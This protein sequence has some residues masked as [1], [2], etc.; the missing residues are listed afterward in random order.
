[1]MLINHRIME[2]AELEGAHQA[3]PV[4]FLALHKTPQG[5]HQEHCPSMCYLPNQCWKKPHC[6]STPG[7][8]PLSHQARKS[9]PGSH[10]QPWPEHGA[11]QH[12]CFPGKVTMAASRQIRGC[13]R[14]QSERKQIAEKCTSRQ[15]GLKHEKWN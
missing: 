1:M 7:P 14:L 15:F 11:E 13:I 3:H 6:I 10:R 5:S 4:L 12:P 9:G 2:S 8:P